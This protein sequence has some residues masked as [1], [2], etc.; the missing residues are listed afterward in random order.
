MKIITGQ[1]VFPAVA[2]GRLH[3]VLR[4]SVPL[5]AFSALN[6]NAELKRFQQA[7][8]ASIL[9]LAA[10]YDQSRTLVDEHNASMFAIYA[11]LVEDE[12]YQQVVQDSIRNQGLTAEYAVYLAGQSFA[13]AFSAMDNDYMRARSADLRNVSAHL[14]GELTGQR[15]TDT[16]A[17]EPT[18]LVDEE[19]SPGRILCMDRSWLTGLVSMSGSTKSHA[20]EL[21]GALHIPAIV[22][23]NITAEQEGHLAIL[24]GFDGM[25]Y[26]DPVPEIFARMEKHSEARHYAQTV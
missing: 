15:Q 8:R 5:S 1:S 20:A 18:I 3:F 25:L 12:D 16:F 23:I 17:A 4:P 7:Q 2:I 13:A 26:V 11:M 21:A 19:F 6:P 14:I 22:H 9:H 10:L 24:D